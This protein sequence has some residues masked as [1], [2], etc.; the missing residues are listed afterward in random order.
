MGSGA[1][2]CEGE[3]TVGADCSAKICDVSIDE[4]EKRFYY[5]EWRCGDV[6]GSNHYVTNLKDVDYKEYGGYIEKCG[7]AQWE[8]FE[9]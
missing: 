6:T 3:F 8:G 5:I 2:V 1:C 4:G 7:Y 9:E